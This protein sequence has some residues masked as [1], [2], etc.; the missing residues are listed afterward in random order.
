[1][2]ILLITIIILVSLLI[3][4]HKR[5]HFSQC[6]NPTTIAIGKEAG[7]GNLLSCYIYRIIKSFAE[8]NHF[9]PIQVNIIYRNNRGRLENVFIERL[10]NVS[11]LTLPAEQRKHLV[12]QI[13]KS[14][15]EYDNCFA[16]WHQENRDKIVFW[17]AMK[18]Y[19]YQMLQESLEPFHSKTES[20]PIIH[21][22]CA[23]VPFVK[24][25][26]YHL[27]Y[28][29]FYDWALQKTQ[30]WCRQQGI[31]FYQ[32]LYIMTCHQWG[33]GQNKKYC[34]AYLEDLQKYLLDHHRIQTKVLSCRNIMEDVKA[35]FE[36]P[37]VI[38]GASSFSFMFAYSSP[39]LFLRGKEMSLGGID[40]GDIPHWMSR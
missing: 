6:Q 40:K 1:M 24:H 13:P 36:A 31:P 14:I 25:E 27:Q 19:V 8:N 20:W 30:N 32:K 35:L 7:L 11:I 39:G 9:A 26:A 23:D 28:Y 33:G 10:R 16:L 29:T 34:D 3:G 37:V 21:L 15:L 17:E 4:I 2:I 38:S 22:R 12:S 5:E 18:P